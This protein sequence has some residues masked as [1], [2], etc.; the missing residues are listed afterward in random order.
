M[1]EVSKLAKHAARGA[2]L[3][4]GMADEAADATVWLSRYGLPGPLLLARLLQLND[5]VACCELTAS[6]LSGK[7]SAPSGRLCPLLAG[8]TLSDCAL[9]LKNG[10]GIE[11]AGLTDP[12]LLL[13]FAASVALENEQAVGL[14]WR[15]VLI[16]T[17]G[18]L[19]HISGDDSNVA[20]ECVS[21]VKCRVQVMP[22][23]KVPSETR[24]Q[25]DARSWTVLSAFAQRTYAP[26]TE[27]SRLLGAGANLGDND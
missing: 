23:G 27:N 13:P 3:S 16:V 12:L 20:A 11:M 4:W 14:E 22:V 7:W 6:T 17:D 21:S 18:H 24:A 26:A 9:R 2:G 5:H 8:A 15:D 1:S 10:E 19:L 25:I